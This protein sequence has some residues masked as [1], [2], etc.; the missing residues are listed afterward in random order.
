MSS[1]GTILFFWR[2]DSDGFGMNDLHNRSDG[3]AN[4][5]PFIEDIDWN[6]FGG[7]MPFEWES[8]VW[9]K[10]SKREQLLED[11]FK[12]EQFPFRAEES[13]PSPTAEVC[14]ESRIY[15]PGIHCHSDWSVHFEDIRASDQWN[16]TITDFTNDVCISSINDNGLKWKAFSTS[17][18]QFRV[19]D[20]E[21]IEI[22]SF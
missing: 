17:S 4:T 10:K 16:E 3:H 9:N 20:I 2:G 18:K 5:L 15:G 12:S 13:A 1:A 14:I 21:V 11:Q 8:P 7:F 6:I 22:D 19:N